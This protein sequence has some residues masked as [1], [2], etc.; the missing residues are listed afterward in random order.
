M[1]GKHGDN[2]WG[3]KCCLASGGKTLLP[4]KALYSMGEQTSV[5]S[6]DSNCPV[7]HGQVTFRINK[8]NDKEMTGLMLSII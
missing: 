6:S 4:G 3:A 7:C 5:T 1:Q 8:I 2:E